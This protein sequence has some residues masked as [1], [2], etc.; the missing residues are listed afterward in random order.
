MSAGSM[1]C[2]HSTSTGT[3]KK[4]GPDTDAG[5]VPMKADP[6]VPPEILQLAEVSEQVL[7]R[8]L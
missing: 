6:E 1:G 3:M 4:H 5:G 2:I 7:L 8:D